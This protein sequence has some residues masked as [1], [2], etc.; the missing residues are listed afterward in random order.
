MWVDSK[1]LLPN[2]LRMRICD[3][4]S[5]I[6]YTPTF[7]SVYN[8]KDNSICY[9]GIGPNHISQAMHTPYILI[10]GVRGT[11]YRRSIVIRVNYANE[12]NPFHACGHY[13]VGD[14]LLFVRL[15][16]SNVIRRMGLRANAIHRVI[17]GTG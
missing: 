2:R 4:I 7:L 5:T 16:A 17:L 9:V 6:S 1:P 11:I 10:M 15:M 14:R 3:Y 13:M 12:F 8:S